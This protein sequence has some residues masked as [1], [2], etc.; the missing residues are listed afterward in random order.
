[1]NRK[2]MFVCLFIYL[3]VHYRNGLREVPTVLVNM[4]T[5]WGCF[6]IYFEMPVWVKDFTTSL[7]QNEDD[8]DDVK[9]LKVSFSSV[10][11]LNTSVF[12]TLHN[13]LISTLA[14]LEWH[15]RTSKGSFE[16]D[17]GN[18]RGSLSYTFAGSQG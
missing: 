14:F 2:L 17:V 8:P 9:A 4:M 18:C 12:S 15:R 1:M 7:V 5:Q 3:F 6:L 11:F 10:G 16:N 13:I